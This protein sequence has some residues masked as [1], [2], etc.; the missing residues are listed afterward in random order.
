MLSRK[1]EVQ[2]L[3]GELERQA[4]VGFRICFEGSSL[5]APDSFEPQAS[6]KEEL[7]TLGRRTQDANFGRR[8]DAFQQFATSYACARRR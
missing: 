4:R 7:W 1:A 2:R 5:P 6:E 3:N 8:K